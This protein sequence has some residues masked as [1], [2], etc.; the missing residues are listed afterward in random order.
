LLR[1]AQNHIGKLRKDRKDVWI[2]REIGEIIDHLP[3][4]LPR[5]LKLDAQGRFA[6]GFYHQRQSQFA[7]RPAVAAV[8]DAQDTEGNEDSADDNG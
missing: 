4:A 6:I 5:S 3:P 2:E 7:S 1:G 8:L